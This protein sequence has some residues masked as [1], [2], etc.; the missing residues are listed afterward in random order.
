MNIENIHCSTVYKNI[1]NNPNTYQNLTTKYT[2]I[3][4]T[5]KYIVT[6]NIL[7]YMVTLS[8]TIGPMPW[9]VF[10]GQKKMFE[11]LGVGG[12]VFSI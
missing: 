9:K 3:Q 12:K 10:Q 5:T 1:V 2:V 4:P 11:T 8:N 7:W 6:Q